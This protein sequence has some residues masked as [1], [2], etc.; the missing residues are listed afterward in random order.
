MTHDLKKNGKEQ[1]AGKPKEVENLNGIGLKL[2]RARTTITDCCGEHK[3]DDEIILYVPDC[4][5][6]DTDFIQGDCAM[7]HFSPKQAKVLSR[8]LWRLAASTHEKRQTIQVE[9]T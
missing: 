6:Y 7:L 5:E 4:S 9:H 1:P 8:K 2:D 3:G